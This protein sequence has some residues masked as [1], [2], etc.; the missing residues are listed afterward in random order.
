MKEPPIDCPLC[1]ASGSVL[2]HDDGLRTYFRCAVCSLVF[3]P[4]QQ[5]V[6]PQVEKT[7][8]DFHEN[9]PADQGYRK[10]L[11]RLFEPLI[12]R[13][14]PADC[15]LD[16][17]SGPGPTLSVMF[18]EAGYPMAVY[19]P[20]YAVDKRPLEIQ[21]DFV[22]CTEVV[23]HFRNPREDLNRLWSCVKP[24]GILGIMTKLT[25]DAQAFATWHYKNDPTHISFFSRETF[26]WLSEL[27]SAELSFV[28]ADVM[29]FTRRQV[30]VQAEHCHQ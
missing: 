9:S 27:W 22:T 20:H 25:L 16:F 6:S 1:D 24:G 7:H 26:Q 28:G 12:A 3:V 30:I 13:L 10:F 21:Y 4:L 23:E 14:K 19:D 8:Y 5:H 2:F 11:G 18:A 17:G 29:L 15:G